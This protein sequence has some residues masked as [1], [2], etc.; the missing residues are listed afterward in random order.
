MGAPT[1]LIGD[2]QAEKS[3][4]FSQLFAVFNDQDRVIGR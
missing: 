1:F 4:K 2:K 3:F